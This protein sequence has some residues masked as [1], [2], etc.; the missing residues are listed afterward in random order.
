M[1]QAASVTAEPLSMQ[2]RPYT[3][4][5]CSNATLSDFAK[6]IE[7]TGDETVSDTAIS[8]EIGTSDGRCI[9]LSFDLADRVDPSVLRRGLLT[10]A[11]NLIGAKAANALF[12]VTES[13][14]N[15]TMG[16]L[17]GQIGKSVD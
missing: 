12:P 5:L 4:T 15:I 6:R 11:H 14:N 10:K 7:V 1:K 2:Q 3:D 16:S 9:L 13:V 17:A 8:G